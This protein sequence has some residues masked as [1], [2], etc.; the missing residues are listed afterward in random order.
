MLAAYGKVIVVTF[1]FRLGILGKLGLVV[2]LYR[3]A[4]RLSEHNKSSVVVD[5]GVAK[6]GPLRYSVYMSLDIPKY[7]KIF[8]I[9]Q[10]L[11]QHIQKIVC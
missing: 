10:L 9:F 3:A 2:A 11:F 4:D 6:G 7:S 5:N 8:Q 1:N